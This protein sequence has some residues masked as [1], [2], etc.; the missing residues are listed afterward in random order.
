MPFPRHQIGRPGVREPGRAIER[1]RSFCWTLCW[2]HVCASLACNHVPSLDVS[3]RPGLPGC[4]QAEAKPTQSQSAGF[5]FYVLVSAMLH[6]AP[7]AHHILLH[8]TIGRRHIVASSWPPS[9][10]IRLQ[11]AT[12]AFPLVMYAPAD[13]RHP[14]LTPPLQT[15]TTPTDCHDPRPHC[16]PR[17]S[18]P[19]Q[20]HTQPRQ[21]LR[22]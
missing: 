16:A 18:A 6:C 4:R 13:G 10:Y 21:P 8:I 2:V 19:Q 14:P 7:G 15:L 1:C 5:T 12:L 11:P 17:R 3:D 20:Q 9:S 22:G